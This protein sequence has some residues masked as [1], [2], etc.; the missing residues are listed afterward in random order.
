L[1]DRGDQLGK[2]E[3]MSRT[4]SG[5]GWTLHLG[6]SLD[7]GTGVMS[8]GAKS[9]DHVITDPPY[10]AEAHTKQRRVTRGGSLTCEPLPFAQMSHDSR[11]LASIAMATVSRRWIVAF[12]QAEAVKAWA[13]EIERSGAVYKRACVW[14]K[15]D[16]MPQFTGDRP[17]MGYESIVTA[18]APGKSAWNGGGKHG[19]YTFAKNGEGPTGHPTTKPA[20]L[21]E[22][23]I[24][25]FTD[26]G[27]LICDPFSGSGSTGV[28]AIRLGRRF[29]GWEMDDAYFEIAVSRLRGSKEQIGLFSAKAPK[30]KQGTLLK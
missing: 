8:L 28:A 20:A 1:F 15:P 17:G 18:H 11:V 7:P 4:E 21:M 26:P 19:V 22:A 9:V 14:I 24:R 3:A 12:C 30:A 25:D 29:V 27:E 10:E 13:D 2:G 6:N 23:L 5:D 16:G